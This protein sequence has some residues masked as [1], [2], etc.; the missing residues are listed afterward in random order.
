MIA[1]LAWTIHYQQVGHISQQ[2]SR[3]VLYPSPIRD[4]RRGRLFP[5]WPYHLHPLIDP[6][7]GPCKS[8]S[9][10]TRPLLHLQEPM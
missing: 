3:V 8:S 9:I 5:S 7:S 1:T 2:L 10:W 4:R 6:S